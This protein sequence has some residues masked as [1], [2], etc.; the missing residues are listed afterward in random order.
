MAPRPPLVPPSSARALFAV[1][2]I[3]APLFFAACEPASSTSGGG[4]STSS[5]TTATP[6]ELTPAERKAREERGQALFLTECAACHGEQGGGDGPAAGHLRIKPRDFLHERL[7][8]RSTA[9]GVMPTRRDIFNTLTRGMPG[10]SMIPFA[11][12]PEEDRWLLTDHVWRLAVGFSKKLGGALPPTPEPPNDAASLARGKAMYEKMECGKCHGPQGAGDGPSAMNLKND[13]GWPIAP[14]DLVHDPFRGGDTAEAVALRLRT[15]MDGTP[16]A[17][18]E[19][20]AAADAIWDLAHHV[21]SLRAPKDPRPTDALS[22]GRLVLSEKHCDGCHSMEGKG[23]SVGP[24][25]DVAAQKLS[26]AWLKG[27]LQAPRAHGKIYP[28]IPYNMPD[29]G[30]GEAEI[31]AILAVLARIANR[32]Y[33]ES[34][35]GRAALVPAKIEEGKRLFPGKCAGCHNL[36]AA[37]PSLAVKP[38]GPDLLHVSARLRFDLMAR[39]V[40]S[41]HMPSGPRKPGASAD[42]DAIAAVLQFVWSESQEGH[43]RRPSGQADS[44]PA[45]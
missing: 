24:S 7:R 22:L 29:P 13:L 42:D 9:S 30:L 4:L 36:G 11:F 3:S 34:P 28:S 6:A 21:V 5:T 37:V 32:S 35:E 38:N 14:R 25:L 16:M 45:K 41:A 15:G 12:L 18:V 31:D 26:F 1:A 27:Y 39:W 23:P 10:T 43:S 44:P 8:L 2:L 40:K 19:G 17:A 33:P 20:T